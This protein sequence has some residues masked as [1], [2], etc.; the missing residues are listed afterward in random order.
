MSESTLLLQK[1]EN[2][3]DGVL[4][5][6]N[7]Q[8]DVK[9]QEQH[10]DTLLAKEKEIRDK[11]PGIIWFCIILL[12]GIGT[13]LFPIFL[14][15]IGAIMGLLIGCLL[16]A[17]FHAYDKF[18]K[19]ADEYHAANVVPAEWEC[20]RRREKI[21]EYLQTPLMKQFFTEIPEEYRSLSALKFFI[22]MLKNGQADTEKELYNLYME[23]TQ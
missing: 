5:L 4:Q 6:M 1:Y 3:L 14:T 16:A 9:A 15:I 7:L 8:D 2:Y 18:K 17:I 20:Q 22:K 19:S 12:G 10:I 13:F 23:Y 21:E 11:V